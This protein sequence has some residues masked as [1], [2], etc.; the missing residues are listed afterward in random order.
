MRD[1]KS[2]QKLKNTISNTKYSQL[3]LSSNLN[4]LISK[5]FTS[6]STKSQNYYQ[7]EKRDRLNS[8]HGNSCLLY[9]IKQENSFETEEPKHS[10]KDS[11]Y[12]KNIKR[13]QTINSST[14][15]RNNKTS[16]SNNKKDNSAQN[17]KRNLTDSGREFVSNMSST[18]SQS[19]VYDDH[20]KKY[21][22]MYKGIYF[23]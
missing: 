2:A 11:I 20:N 16:I 7:E 18:D 1:L 19:S 9:D 5:S 10:D 15:P 17:I 21:S 8:S 22:D 6:A 4:N 3:I 14:L 13:S 12:S 23:Y